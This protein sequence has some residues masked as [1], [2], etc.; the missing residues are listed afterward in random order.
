MMPRAEITGE[1]MALELLSEKGTCRIWG[2]RL[3]SRSN[4]GV[5]QQDLGDC[6]GRTGGAA[7]S[8]SKSTGCGLSQN[9]GSSGLVSKFFLQVVSTHGHES[10]ENHFLI[11]LLV[12]QPSRPSSPSG[13]GP[14]PVPWLLTPPQAW[15]SLVP[16]LNSY[17][18]V[19]NFLSRQGWKYS[20]GMLAR[21][22]ASRSRWRGS[23]SGEPNLGSVKS[24]H[25]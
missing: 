3:G 9:L 6:L 7:C 2:R 14:W 15:A 19:A 25:L 13:R 16:T 8:R 17:E 12:S 11:S 20:S 18:A 1:R 10:L 4:E 24:H 23:C 21:G 22:Q 5:L